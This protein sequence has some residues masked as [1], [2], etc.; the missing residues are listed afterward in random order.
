MQPAG[1]SAAPAQARTV[2]SAAVSKMDFVA[3]CA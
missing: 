1:L 3:D 2:R